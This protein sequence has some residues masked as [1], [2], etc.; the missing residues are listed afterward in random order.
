MLIITYLKGLSWYE[1][2]NILTWFRDSCRKV[3]SF[4]CINTLHCICCC[5]LCIV[6][7]CWWVSLIISFFWWHLIGAPFLSSLVSA[8]CRLQQSLHMSINFTFL[9]SAS[10]GLS[11]LQF[12]NMNSMRNLFITGVAF[13]L[14]LS[15]PEYFREYTAKALHGPAHTSGVWVS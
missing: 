1:R 15:V 10:V 11:F 3:W 5:I 12:T 8:V 7:S 13:F 2:M 6:W 4:V 14:G 9:F